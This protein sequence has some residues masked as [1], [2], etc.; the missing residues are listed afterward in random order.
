ML[1]CAVKLAFVCLACMLTEKA[2]L[3]GSL[4]ELGITIGFLLAYIIGY[5]FI[6]IENGW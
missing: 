2:R 5:L 1:C 3:L 4:N 6:S